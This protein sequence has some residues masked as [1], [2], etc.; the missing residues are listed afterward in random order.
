MR[1]IA[2]VVALVVSA[3]ASRKTHEIMPMPL[4]G[5]AD[6]VIFVVVYLIVSQSIKAYLDE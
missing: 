2:L 5:L 3:G 6:L 1:A 4:S